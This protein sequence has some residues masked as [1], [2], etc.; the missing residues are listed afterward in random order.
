VSEDSPIFTSDFRCERPPSTC[1][2]TPCRSGDK[3]R[4]FGPLTSLPPYAFGS[5][6][7]GRGCAPLKCA[8]RIGRFTQSLGQFLNQQTPAHRGGW[9]IYGGGVCGGRPGA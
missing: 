2:K 6:L 4:A 1:R 5:P 8:G 7:G 9:V 3:N